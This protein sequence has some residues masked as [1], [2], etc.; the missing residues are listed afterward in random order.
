MADLWVCTCVH[1]RRPDDAP[2]DRCGPRCLSLNRMDEA[3]CHRCGKR[4]P[5]SLLTRGRL[6][7][8]ALIFVIALAWLAG[9][10]GLVVGMPAHV[11]VI[12]MFGCLLYILVA[13]AWL[14]YEGW[15]TAGVYADSSRGC[16]M[17]LID[18]GVTLGVFV[19]AGMFLVAGGMFLALLFTGVH[20]EPR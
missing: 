14:I 12:L 3:R 10:T 4:R 1:T 20:N 17:R 16:R 8:L 6:V 18:R 9:E 19:A 5:H 2:C 7:T 13:I 15:G 11:P